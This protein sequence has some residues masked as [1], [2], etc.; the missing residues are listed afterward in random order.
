MNQ[1]MVQQRS[2]LLRAIRHDQ[3]S[4]NTAMVQ[5]KSAMHTR[6]HLG[7][8]AAAKPYRW[9][10]AGLAVGLWLGSRSR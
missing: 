2:D 1:E 5:L 7:E 6:T 4:L 10:A 3:A 8:Q 9:L